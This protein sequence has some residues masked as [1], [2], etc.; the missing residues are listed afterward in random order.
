MVRVKRGT[1]AN[2]R[3][4]NVLAKTK[5]FRFA[6]SKTFRA[7]ATAI[8]HAGN[9]AFRGRKEKKRDFRALWN[10]K[11]GA[12]VRAL[13]MSYSRFIDALKKK[14]IQLNRKSLAAIAEE[15]PAIFEK[16]VANVE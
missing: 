7:A 4:K 16:I 5:G 9:N 6:R 13:G 11:I 1:T 15:A 14:D 12:S 10:I 2:K 8:R 3:R